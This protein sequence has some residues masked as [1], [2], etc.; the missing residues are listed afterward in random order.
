MNMNPAAL[1]VIAF[2]TVVGAV[3]GAALIGAAVSLGVVTYFTV[4]GGTRA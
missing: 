1:L 3:F 2:G 4:F